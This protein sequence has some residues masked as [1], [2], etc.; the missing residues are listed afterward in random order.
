[1]LELDL[2][3][4][5]Q[6][7]EGNLGSLPGNPSMKEWLTKSGNNYY[8]KENLRGS[9]ISISKQPLVPSPIQHEKQPQNKPAAQVVF[10]PNLLGQPVAS[11]RPNTS[12]SHNKSV[13]QPMTQSFQGFPINERAKP[14]LAQHE[15][16]K[17]T[18]RAAGLPPREYYKQAHSH[19][20]LGVC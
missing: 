19:K 6:W 7:R 10:T 4:L 16:T 9:S 1:M 5:N 17:F 14:R 11:V 15:S 8:R 2:L 3:D 12:Y 13:R 20:T 18:G